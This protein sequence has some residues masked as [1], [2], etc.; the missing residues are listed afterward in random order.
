MIRR[1]S[2]FFALVPLVL[3]ISTAADAVQYV[4][5]DVAQFAQGSYL[6]VSAIN[7]SGVVVGSVALQTGTTS[8]FTWSAAS[9]LN[10]LTSL[11]AGTSARA[12]AINDS[13][14]VVG[15]SGGFATLWQDGQPEDL[16]TL[17]DVGTR[18]A[19][20]INNAGQVVGMS[21]LLPFLWSRATGIQGLSALS[22]SSSV[23][24]INDAGVIAGTSNGKPC[25]YSPGAGLTYITTP[26]ISVVVKDIN[27]SGQ[28]L[29][30]APSTIIGPSSVWQD[31][32]LSILPTLP[33]YDI[34][35]GNDINNRGQVVGT[36]GKQ[37]GLQPVCWS[38]ADGIQA[39]PALAGSRDY[40]YAVNDHCVIA[41][42]GWDLATDTRHLLIWTPVPEP[43]SIL[44]LVAGLGGCGVCIRRRQ[45]KP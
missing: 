30:K 29:L 10:Y 9:G 6:T 31:G 37:G 13:G 42:C 33:G 44:A 26:F 27:D 17:G 40:P 41:G 5:Q 28:V 21:G 15:Y 11:V 16:G 23:R 43:S 35:V 32:Q 22:G 24:A 19:Y 39:L 12:N 1:I 36:C 8:A 4:V 25:V 14:Q 20:A 7:N 2:L 34:P 45:R 18:E 38:E 3:L